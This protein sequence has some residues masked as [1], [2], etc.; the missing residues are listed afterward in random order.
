MREFLRHMPAFFRLRAALSAALIFQDLVPA[1]VALFALLS[2]HPAPAHSASR[3]LNFQGRL[4]NTVNNPQTGPFDFKFSLYNAPT[5]GAQLWPSGGATEDQTLSVTN[6]VFSAQ[7]GSVTPIP[8]SVFQGPDSS[9]VYLEIQVQ[10]ETL[11]PRQKMLTVPFAMTLMGRTTEHFVSTGAVNQA[12]EGVKTF[13]SFPQKSGSTT[14]SGS[15]EF[16]TKAYVDSQATAGSGWTDG[17]TT[18]GLTTAGDNV[19]IGTA[20]SVAKLHLLMASPNVSSPT[21][22]NGTAS[23]I[24]TASG[25]GGGLLL[26]DSDSSGGSGG[27]LAFGTA[28]GAFAVIKGDIW[29]GNA[30]SAG[31]LVFGVRGDWNSTTI[32][33]KMRLHVNG[34][35]GVGTNVPAR[36]LHLYGSNPGLAI[37]D[38]NSGGKQWVFTNVGTG[39][40]SMGLYNATN[41][42]WSWISK[43]DGNVGIGITPTEKLHLYNGTFSISPSVDSSDKFRFYVVGTNNP[44]GVIENVWDTSGTPVYAH[45]VLNPSGGNIGIGTDSP[46]AKLHVYNAAARVSGASASLTVD[47]GSTGGTM[48]SAIS[49]SLA[50]TGSSQILFGRSAAS[51]ES[52][53][54]GF[55]YNSTGG[56]SSY[57]WLVNY[58]DGQTT[59]GIVLKKG[60]NVGLGNAAPTQKLDITGN[61]TI[62]GR[63]YSNEWIEHPNYTGLYSANNAAYFYPNNGTFGSWR[64]A[65]SRSGWAGL[66]FDTAAGQMTLMMGHSTQ[67]WGAQQI[68]VHRN[69]TGWVWYFNHQDLIAAKFVDIDNGGFY[70]DPASTSN[71]NLFY[72]AQGYNGVE[73]DVNNNAYFVDP[74]GTSIFNE[75]RANIFYDFGDPTFYCDPAATSILNTV[76]ASLLYDR[77]NPGYYV[78]PDVSSQ[79]NNIYYTGALT[80][81]SDQRFKTDIHPLAGALEKISALNPVRFKWNQSFFNAY[82]IEKPSKEQSQVQVG[83]I[84]QEVE[85]VFPEVVQTAESGYKSIDYIKLTPLLLQGIKEQQKQ[86]EDLKKRIEA[87]EFKGQTK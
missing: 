79:F 22:T 44:Y 21:V 39:D 11:S 67:G 57:L 78:N 58:G 76:Y 14:P 63:I 1:G 47:N 15:A 53:V 26:Q 10:G 62:S 65:G 16:A 18:V 20:G 41:S 80:N 59:Q 70:V 72:R 34:Y 50:S 77:D 28:Q 43:S 31:S 51:N 23:N 48:L 5:G 46:A 9:D 64:I 85:K 83:L 74:N 69:G 32:D 7:V 68:G 2:L 13:A 73:Y 42:V 60:G 29:N 19:G 87:L 33:E 17:G 82:K 75:M 4:T 6:G 38:L 12:I 30:N 55:T 86:I 40:G 8:L 25:L 66:E 61:M 52:G 81:N 3:A 54:A 56:N 35:V 24:T 49:S 84:A 45:T 37:Q 71:V 36:L 27:M